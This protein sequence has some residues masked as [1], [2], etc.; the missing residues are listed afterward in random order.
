MIEETAVCKM[1]GGVEAF[2]GERDVEGDDVGI[3]FLR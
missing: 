1:I 2:M 3:T